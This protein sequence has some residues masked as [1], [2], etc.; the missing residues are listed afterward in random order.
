MK[1]ILNM[2][3]VTLNEY[4][5][6]ERSSRYKA[7]KIKKSQTNSVAFIALEYGFK[8]KQKQYDIIFKWYKPNDRKDHD[9]IAFAKKFILD[10][11][12]KAKSLPNDNPKY[13]RNFQDIFIIDK[14]R[15]YIACEVFFIE[16]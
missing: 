11:L 12:V 2:G 4:I 15:N 14:T 10:G 3:F 13:I 1:L 5:N 6:A 9:N 16:V 8:L 7:A